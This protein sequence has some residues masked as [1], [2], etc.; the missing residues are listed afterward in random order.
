MAT[1]TRTGQLL[2][3]GE[4]VDAVAGGRFETQDPAT[5]EVLGSIAEGIW[6]RDVSAAHNLAAQIRAGTVWVNMANPVDAGSSWGG[7]KASGWGREMGKY[8][9]DLY[10]ELKSV[11]VALD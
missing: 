2:I 9:L 7:F 11:W 3:G 5:G 8:A 10:T 4:W 6:T 1:A